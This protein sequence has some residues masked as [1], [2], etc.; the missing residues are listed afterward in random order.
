M[1]PTDKVEDGY[2]VQLKPVKCPHVQ[3]QLSSSTAATGRFSECARSVVMAAYWH[4]RMCCPAML[5][6]CSSLARRFE[7]WGHDEDRRLLH[8]L[9]YWK[10]HGSEELS[11][12]IGYSDTYNLDIYVDAD[13]ASDPFSR[14]STTGA[15]VMLSGPA[16]AVNLDNVC[17]QQPWIALRRC[18]FTSS[19]PTPHIAAASA[20][21]WSHFPETS[22]SR[23]WR[24]S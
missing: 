5:Q 13:H 1:L 7:Q 17:K 10:H 20:A 6:P 23:T 21:M 12:R 2:G 18:L 4:A 16:T 14:R 19:F 22:G 8:A 11:L 24:A 15:A 3:P 9:A